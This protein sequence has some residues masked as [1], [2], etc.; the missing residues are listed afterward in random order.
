[1]KRLVLSTALALAVSVA[2]AEQ[3]APHPQLIQDAFNDPAKSMAIGAYTKGVLDTVKELQ[4]INYIPTLWCNV[5]NVDQWELRELINANDP[6][7]FE[8]TPQ[9]GLSFIY[10]SVYNRYAC[11]KSF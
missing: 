1:M 8:D 3:L 6:T 7:L 11:N 2:S 9:G 4:R 10:F 5:E